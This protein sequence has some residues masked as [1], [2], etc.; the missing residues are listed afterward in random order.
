ME[1]IL[2]H[3]LSVGSKNNLNYRLQ[4]EK[5]IKSVNKF[6]GTELNQFSKSD[7]LEKIYKKISVQEM[8]DFLSN[9]IQYL[10][11]SKKIKKKN[12]LLNEYYM[13]GIDMTQTHKLNTNKLQSGKEIKGLLF[14]KSNG[15]KI[16][17]RKVVEAK[18]LLFNGLSIPLMSEFVRNDDSVDGKFIK[19]DC[20]LNAAYRLIDN[21][22][23]E[24]PR[25]KICLLLDGLYPNET[26]FKKC[27]K[28]NWKYIITLKEKKIPTL[29]KNFIEFKRLENY[30]E[31][32]KQITF[33]INQRY[34]FVKLKYLEFD[35]T[36]IQ[37]KEYKNKKTEYF[38][39]FITNLD[40]EKDNVYKISSGGRLRWK[41]EHSFNKQK[42]L[43]FNL[44]HVYSKNENA[45]Q[46]YHILLQIAD[47]IFQFMS[48]TLTSNGENILYDVFGSL[49]EFLHEIYVSFREKIGNIEK[50][51]LVK[52]LILKAPKK[53]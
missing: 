26:I 25:L 19:Q 31:K 1:G 41:I 30:E 23:K 20:E 13:I 51:F 38:N 46:C 29:Y 21:I 7:N 17:S 42:N 8:K 36:C 48:Y 44:K 49:I 18:L 43:L 10:I 15:K 22:K 33:N 45:S 47:L 37:V 34:K 9:I 12:L 39:L 27:K 2:M 35:L 6:L 32:K 14:Q 24:Y 52:H 16:Y 50:Y 28:N 4:D 40:V 11:K 53:K 5:I 3:L